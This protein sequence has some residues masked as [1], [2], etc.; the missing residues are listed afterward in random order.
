[1]ILYNE[2]INGSKHPLVF[3][4][5]DS[6]KRVPDLI[7]TIVTNDANHKAHKNGLCDV[8]AKVMC[9][10]GKIPSNGRHCYLDGKKLF[11]PDGELLPVKILWYDPP[12]DQYVSGYATFTCSAHYE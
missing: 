11:L 10:I 8:E 4:K 6:G 3:L 9:T 1:M 12:S 2:K 7:Y 5:T